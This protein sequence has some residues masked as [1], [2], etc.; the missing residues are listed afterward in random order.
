MG[1][2]LDLV[3]QN[4]GKQAPHNESEEKIF[5][6]EFPPGFHAYPALKL[7]GI[8]RYDD[9][10]LPGHRLL[11]QLPVFAAGEHFKNTNFASIPSTVVLYISL[12]EL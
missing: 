6:R 8:A 12:Y 5:P 3:L 7:C 4:K 2:I 10:L 9:L 11:A 1:G